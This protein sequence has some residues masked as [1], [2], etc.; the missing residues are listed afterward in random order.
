MTAQSTSRIPRRECDT[1]D[2][3]AWATHRADWTNDGGFYCDDCAEQLRHG[4]DNVIPL[5]R[6]A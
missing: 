4:G 6:G 5:E 1:F 3:A 2:C